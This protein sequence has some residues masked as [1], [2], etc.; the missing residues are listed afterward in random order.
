MVTLIKPAS[1]LQPLLKRRMI[2]HD[3]EGSYFI[4]IS[5]TLCWQNFAEQI[6]HFEFPLSFR[7][8]NA[9]LMLI[10]KTMPTRKNTFI[11]TQHTRLYIFCL[12]WGGL[13]WNGLQE[14]LDLERAKESRRNKKEKW[15]WIIIGGCFLV[16]KWEMAENDK[17]KKCS[18]FVSKIRS[19]GIHFSASILAATV[20][21]VE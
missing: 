19:R 6:S 18:C 12:N 4:R 14:S 3:G 11:P 10:A 8:K 17:D 9:N 16:N 20:L 1:F 7:I 13:R 5:L 2:F 21:D 15:R